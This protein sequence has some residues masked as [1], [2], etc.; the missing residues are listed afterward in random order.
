M[1]TLQDLFKS[2]K[3]DLYGKSE[4]IRI[5]S[6]GL[7][8]PPR[9]AALLLSSPTKVGDFIAGQVQG[10]FGGSANRPSDTIFKNKSFLAKPVSAFTNASQLKYSIEAGKD[11]YLKEAPPYNSFIGTIKQGAS[12]PLGAAANIGVDLIK[13]LKQKNPTRGLP[14]GEKFQHT[15]GGKDIKE[16][17][18]FHTHYTEYNDNKE[19]LVKT[20]GTI[21]EREGNQKINWDTANN[22]AQGIE[23]LQ[24]FKD[25]EKNGLIGGILSAFDLNDTLK[26]FELQNQVWVLFKK[27]GNR[28]TVPFTGT[29]SGISET[30]TP[31]WTNF[32]YLGSPFK[33]YRYLGVERTLNFELKLYYTTV[34]EKDV[35]IKKI[36][37][38]KSLAFPYEQISQIQY[39]NGNKE[40]QIYS[41]YAFSPNL[42][43]LSIGD[44]Y[45]NLFGYIESLSFSVDDNTTWPNENVNMSKGGS[46]KLYPSVISVSIGMHIIEQHPADKD[47]GITK[48]RY[49]FDGLGMNIMET[50]E[51]KQKEAPALPNMPSQPAL[52]TNIT[53]Q[54][55]VE[56]NEV[57]KKKKKKPHPQETKPKETIFTF[58]MPIIK[59]TVYETDPLRE[60]RARIKNL[61]LDKP[62]KT[63][64]VGR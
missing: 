40:N 47:E 56:K 59:D 43:T 4:S 57:R 44:M 9:A 46:N 42:V 8:N 22:Y 12:S 55:P 49:N 23:S 1:P 50:Q 6:R 54:T 48:Y 45:R 38:L 27:Y 15:I 32:R 34:N 13:G 20:I 19:P 16:T 25:Y 2:Q 10:A 63:V 64:N 37:Y 41:Q 31:E 26:R 30:V 51:E 5:D 36:N 18:T 58:Q 28:E 14:Y 29:I 53:Q 39:N 62:I 3:K 17:T 33:S 11:Y 35:M 61:G 7:I 60:T 24:N 21:K 52:P